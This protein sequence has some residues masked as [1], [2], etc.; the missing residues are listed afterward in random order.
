[1]CYLVTLNC[2]TVVGESCTDFFLEDTVDVSLS[3]EVPESS[4]PLELLLDDDE[5]ADLVIGSDFCFCWLLFGIGVVLYV[6]IVPGNFKQ[7]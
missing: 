7:F 1:M 4:L 3:D 5:S 6:D 2:G